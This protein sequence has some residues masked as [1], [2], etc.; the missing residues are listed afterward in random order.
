MFAMVSRVAGRMVRE[1][2]S[3]Q[4]NDVRA[5]VRLIIFPDL[6]SGTE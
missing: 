4:L 5:S 6:I 3:Q 2:D 1:S